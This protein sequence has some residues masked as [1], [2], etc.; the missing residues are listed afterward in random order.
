[1]VLPILLMGRLQVSMM[2]EHR[3]G[4]DFLEWFGKIENMTY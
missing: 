3:S 4:D 2:M 1:M